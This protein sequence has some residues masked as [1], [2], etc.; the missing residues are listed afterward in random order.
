MTEGDPKH[1]D[2]AALDQVSGGSN[3]IGKDP[4][5][6]ILPGGGGTNAPDGDTFIPKGD[7]PIPTPAP[8]PPPTPPGFP[9]PA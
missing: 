6:P 5:A 8:S 1:L 2:D 3:P 7:G 4:R 9:K